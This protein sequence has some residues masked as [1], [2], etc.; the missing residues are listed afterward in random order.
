M[1]RNR[2]SVRTSPARTA[3][4]PAGATRDATSARAD[5]FRAMADVH[6]EKVNAAIWA[7]LRQN[8]GPSAIIRALANDECGIGY[9][10]DL[11][12]STFYDRKRKLIRQFGEPAAVVERGEEDDAADAIRREALGAIRQTVRELKAK[13]HKTKAEIAT[14]NAALL[15]ADGYQR[16]RRDDANKGKTRGDQRKAGQE[17]ST[18]T[19][20]S[21]LGSQLADITATQDDASD[22][23]DSV[24]RSRKRASAQLAGTT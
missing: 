11:K 15:A 19:L 22:D 21:R 8:L 16:R 5:T 4:Q 17:S 23:G 2:A 20:A 13:P 14:L 12:R 24:V 7:M 10:V 18:P 1:P 9:P 6:D 3:A